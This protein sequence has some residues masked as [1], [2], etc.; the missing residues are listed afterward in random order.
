MKRGLSIWVLMLAIVLLAAG[1][2]AGGCGAK[3]PAASTTSTSAHGSTTTAGGDVS[4]DT[5]SPGDSG[6]GLTGPYVEPA[7]LDVTAGR[8]R[9]H[10]PTLAMRRSPRP[11]SRCWRDR[12][13][14]PPSR[15]RSTGPTSSGTCTRPPAT[16]AFRCSSPPTRSSMPTTGSSTPCSSAWKRSPCSIRRRP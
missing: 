9:R 4:T 1:L 6:G 2:L 12:A 7:Y 14:W 5:T 15:I 16:K 13:S 10:Q 11:R 3:K 8:P